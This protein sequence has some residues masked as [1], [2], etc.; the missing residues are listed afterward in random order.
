V[1]STLRYVLTFCILSE[2]TISKD[3]NFHI[4]FSLRA[5]LPQSETLVTVLP[6]S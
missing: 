3:S 1:G 2:V 5:S 6:A 4:N